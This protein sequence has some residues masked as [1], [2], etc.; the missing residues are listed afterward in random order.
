MK[1]R[2]YEDL[3]PLYAVADYLDIKDLRLLIVQ[4]LHLV[5]RKIGAF[6]T[7]PS[8]DAYLEDIL[9]GWIL[10]LNF[11]KYAKIAYKLPAP[12]P[13]NGKRRV[14][15]TGIRKPFI[16]IFTF[17]RFALV[18]E[19]KFIRQLG[20]IPGLLEDVIHCMVK[21]DMVDRVAWESFPWHIDCSGCHEGPVV[22][23]EIDEPPHDNFW[24]TKDKCFRCMWAASD[25][26]A[27]GVD[28]V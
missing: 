22:D 10:R 23:K 1:L 17:T 2:L 5:N 24:L 4:Q 6:L 25:P 7:G 11:V 15:P 19:E 16:E 18:G 21:I 13:D 14:Y 3:V 20:R 8:G 9:Y 26:A 12:A 28:V 27:G